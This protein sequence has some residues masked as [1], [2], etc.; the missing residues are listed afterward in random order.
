MRIVY[1]ECFVLL[2]F[3]FFFQLNDRLV[4]GAVEGQFEKL[5][6]KVNEV[7]SKNG[8]FTLVLCAGSF[9]RRQKQDFEAD[10]RNLKNFQL[11]GLL[12]FGWILEPSLTTLFVILS[13][14]SDL[15]C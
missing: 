11:K 13:D 4:F 2:T 3:F 10:Y 5:V 6:N 14:R 7:N 1:W 15:L 12:I 8:P 9:F